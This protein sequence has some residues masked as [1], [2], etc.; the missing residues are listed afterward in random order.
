MTK[1]EIL[2]MLHNK[3][4]KGNQIVVKNGGIEVLAEKRVPMY[5]FDYTEFV[6][7]TLGGKVETKY[8]HMLDQWTFTIEC[9]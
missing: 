7:K 2:N 8:I 9:E 4:Y 6:Y 5:E 1:Q 3:G